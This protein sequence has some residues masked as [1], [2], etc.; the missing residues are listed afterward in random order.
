MRRPMDEVRFLPML[1]SM[2]ALLLGV[3]PTSGSEP[4]PLVRK[5]SGVEGAIGGCSVAAQ[6]PLASRF[7]ETTVDPA[8]RKREP[9]R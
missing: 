2:I 4:P 8:S 5:G 7:S 1:R 3:P 9:W 6:P